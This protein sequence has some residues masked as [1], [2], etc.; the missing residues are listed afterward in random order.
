MRSKS[1]TITI[2]G[3][4]AK[5]R[6]QFIKYYVYSIEICRF[7]RITLFEKRKFGA[8]PYYAYL[9]HDFYPYTEDEKEYKKLINK[10][11]QKY[12]IGYGL[13]NNKNLDEKDNKIQIY[14][15]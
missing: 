10:M 7:L 9:C 5:A 2:G 13:K 6:I 3:K 11:A 15:S 14:K 8:I 1:V 12:E 4:K